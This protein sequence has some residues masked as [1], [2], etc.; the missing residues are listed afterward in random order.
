[1]SISKKFPDISEAVSTDSLRPIMQYAVVQNGRIIATDSHILVN[2][3]L[4]IWIESEEELANLEGKIFNIKLLK[5]I[6]KN[7]SE[8]IFQ[9]DRILFKD[10]DG[11][12]EFAFYSGRIDQKGYMETYNPETEEYSELGTYVN[13]K[14]VVPMTDKNKLK[15]DGAPELQE[16]N[17]WMRVLAK[18]V[19]S[20]S[21]DKI[22]MIATGGGLKPL[23]VT[24]C[25][26]AE[27]Q[28][29]EFS[30]YAM[31]MPINTM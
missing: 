21:T 1:M 29:D 26:M 25:K 23:I 20:F 28:H 3:S 9:K 27:Y 13:W 16:A 12:T 17:F 22:R 11:F 4:N 30:E 7:W 6:T 5:K 15:L 10:K 14:N 19:K 31:V 8:L 24:P 18:A 2:I